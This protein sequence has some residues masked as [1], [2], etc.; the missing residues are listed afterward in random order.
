[1]LRRHGNPI[2]AFRNIK[3]YCRKVILN[4][5]RFDGR[6][7]AGL[8]AQKPHLLMRAV[9]GACTGRVRC[10]IILRTLVPV[11]Y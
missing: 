1:M 4:A 6:K 5:I 7:I 3:Q 8:K 11:P 9:K 2:S 10:I